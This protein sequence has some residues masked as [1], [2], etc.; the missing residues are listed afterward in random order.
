MNGKKKTFGGR[1]TGIATMP[2]AGTRISISLSATLRRA[3]ATALALAALIV[4]GR[5]AA[6]A[7]LQTLEIVSASGV[8]VFSVELAITDKEREKGLMFRD[9]L[10]DGQGMLFRFDP[11]QQIMMW[12]KNTPLSL[13]MIFIRGDGHILRI[14]ENTEPQSTRII[15]SGGQAAAVLEV[16]AG[17]AQKYGIRPGDRVAF[18]WFQTR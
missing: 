17:T 2:L 15:S 7:D 9:N 12:M 11:P 3:I 8:H 4:T 16:I 6:A 10:P 5:I 18:P 13:D 1:A 14:A